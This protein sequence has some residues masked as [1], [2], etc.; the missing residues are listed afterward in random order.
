MSESLV[1]VIIPSYNRATLLRTRSLTS[2][3]KQTYKNWEAIVVGDGPCNGALKEAVEAVGDPRI[4]Y[5]E[6]SRPDYSVFSKSEFWN[7]AGAAARNHGLSLARGAIIAP[8][9]DDDEF[10]PNH[11]Q[12]SVDAIATGKGDFIY[13]NVI[14][15]N[16]ETDSEY[17][18]YFPWKD[19]ITR[20]LFKRRNIMF[21][22]TV[23][24][25]AHYAKLC[26][27]ENGSNPADYGLWISIQRKGARIYS[28][29]T[30]QAVYYGDRH[31]GSIRVSAP[32][33]PPFDEFKK[34]LECIFDSHMLSNHGV[35]VQELE[36][37]ISNWL[38]VKH[39]VTTPSGDIALILA[40]NALREICKKGRNEVIL[41][42]YAH[43][44]LIN[45]ILWNDFEP[46]FCDIDPNT[47]CISPET[48]APCLR[49]RTAIIATLHPHGYLADMRRL[50]RLAQENGVLL[51]ADGA[52]SL[53]GELHGCRVGGF[54][55]VEVFSL[56][57][58]KNLTSGEGGLVCCNNDRL[59]AIVRCTARYGLED[60]WEVSRP[61]I[62][63]KLAEIPAALA[64]AGL[65]YLDE[66][67][68]HRR[69]MEKR[70]RK[71]FK[72]CPQIRMLKPSHPTALSACKDMVIILQT[73]EA[74]KNLANY[75][76]GYRIVTRPYYRVLHSM[77]AYA[78]FR[79]APL[80]STEALA[81]C[82]V[83]LPLYGWIREEVI[84]LVTAVVKEGFQ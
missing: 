53:G 48:V 50:H 58:T 9:D 16:F 69:R 19:P 80:P 41:P 34:Y 1:T 71:S 38:Q 78:H 26:Y 23:C 4:R 36:K 27:P 45:A 79:H 63:G 22:S 6:I 20:E 39:V 12:E 61:G 37:N 25:D 59:A 70:Y 81:D 66:W 3:L 32:S 67:L 15:R 13:G 44:S 77:P 60:N 2:L 52:A 40:F 65:P 35:F 64:L 24:Y 62:N 21:H 17:N 11:L 49:S 10:M 84:D 7:V 18:D 14:V 5:S 51:M 68:A 54:G 30:P 82:T 73:P 83:C 72:N 29:D 56:S 42:S 31:S 28:L 46:V 43:P 8:L 76:D 74:A 33:L 75:L 57:G 55:D 47:L